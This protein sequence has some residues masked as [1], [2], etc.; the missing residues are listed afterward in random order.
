M[1][2]K[3]YDPSLSTGALLPRLNPKFVIKTRHLLTP[4]NNL[5][6][7]TPQ[8][9]PPDP[10]FNET[11]APWLTGRPTPDLTHPFT[12]S[13]ITYAYKYQPTTFTTDH[14]VTP[15]TTLPLS[16]H[17]FTPIQ[18]HRIAIGT[19]YST[20]DQDTFVFKCF[21]ES[22]RH[23]SFGRWYDFKRHYNGA[24][25]VEL[26]QFW[27]TVEGCERSE[28][29]GRRSFRRKDKLGDHVRKVHAGFA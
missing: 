6:R 7:P 21:H 16:M 23:K 12:N 11:Q 20:S 18:T 13:D 5:H 25:A 9:Y 10:S 15:I 8:Y 19:V 22:C 4:T 24:H 28:M 3:R 17:H 26:P 1:N 27:C 2:T 14:I 29:L